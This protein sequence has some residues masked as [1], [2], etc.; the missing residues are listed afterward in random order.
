MV[1]TLEGDLIGDEAEVLE[2]DNG[3]DELLRQL[4]EDGDDSPDGAAARLGPVE[5]QQQRRVPK[6]AAQGPCPLLSD[7][8]IAPAELSSLASLWREVAPGKYEVQAGPSLPAFLLCI[9]CI[10]WFSFFL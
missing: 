6:A 9:F 1:N 5:R 2:G 8:V 4:D 3:I 10:C 7:P